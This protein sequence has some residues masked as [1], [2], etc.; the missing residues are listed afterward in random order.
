[1]EKHTFMAVPLPERIQQRL[2]EYS[3][4]VQPELPLKK[5]TGKGDY[6]ITLAFL[7]T[8]S[9]QQVDALK[10]ELGQQI[11]LHKPFQLKVDKPGVF[12]NISAPRVF[13]LGMESSEQ[14]SFLQK[15]VA[16]T[17][18]KTGFNIE[19]R[20]FRPHI[21][22]GKRWSGAAEQVVSLKEIPEP[23]LLDSLKWQVDELI[24]YEIQPS[25]QPMY[26]PLHKFKLEH[27]PTNEC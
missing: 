15:D 10:R 12:G 2:F 18:R 11:Q 19:K 17:C 1:M 25:R 7:G 20:P 23:A 14:L 24:L 21:T 4:R 6:H 26:V 8:T 13:W 9:E 22:I 5:W 27:T 3:A 16:T